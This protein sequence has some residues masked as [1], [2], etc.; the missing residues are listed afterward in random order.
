MP[1]NLMAFGCSRW[2]TSESALTAIG[3]SAPI[4][5]ESAR[6]AEAH[7]YVAVFIDRPARVAAQPDVFGEIAHVARVGATT[8][9]PFAVIAVPQVLKVFDLAVARAPHVIGGLVVVAEGIGVEILPPDGL[10]LVVDV[11]DGCMHLFAKALGGGVVSD[12]ERLGRRIGR[13]VAR[14]VGRHDEAVRSQ[15]RHQGLKNQRCARAPGRSGHRDSTVA[16]R[17][18]DVTP[19]S[20]TF[21]IERDRVPR[22]CKHSLR[23]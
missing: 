2:T 5:V 11:I 19:T 12:G 15:F 17:R 3:I 1:Q 10:E 6:Q 9:V 18:A 23:R 20:A 14:R 21:S 7:K 4:G 8:E 22:K 13:A 16:G